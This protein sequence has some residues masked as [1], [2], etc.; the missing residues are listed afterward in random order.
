MQF[1]Q[2][3]RVEAEPFGRLDL[4]QG[5]RKSNAFVLTAHRRKFVEHAEFHSGSSVLSRLAGAG[6]FEPPHG[7]IKIRCLTTWLRPNRARCGKII[8]KG[9]GRQPRP[10]APRR[11]AAPA[12][13]EKPPAPRPGL[14]PPVRADGALEAVGVQ[15]PGGAPPS[16]HGRGERQT[17]ALGGKPIRE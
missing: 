9:G 3:Q 7:G 5:P 8:G 10:H 1:G 16:G 12:G 14:S 2:P 11:P 4:V 15:R 13:R 6:G 17:G